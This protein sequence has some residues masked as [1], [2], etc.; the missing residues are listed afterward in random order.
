MPPHSPTRNRTRPLEALPESP[1]GGLLG[2]RRWHA[3]GVGRTEQDLPTPVQRYPDPT[4]VGRRLCAS[5]FFV[6]GLCYRPRI[7]TRGTRRLRAV[8]WHTDPLRPVPGILR[9]DLRPWGAL[10]TCGVWFRGRR[11]RCCR[12]WGKSLHHK[13]SPTPDGP[14]VRK[15]GNLWRD[16][17]RLPTT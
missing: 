16:L 8:L 1:S 12:G 4:C 11:R 5:S 3:R 2:P 13:I 14:P 9:R 7:D 17:P 6:S 15:L 10:R